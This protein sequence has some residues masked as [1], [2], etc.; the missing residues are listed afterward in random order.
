MSTHA[1]VTLLKIQRAWNMLDCSGEVTYRVRES[2]GDS[3][4]SIEEVPVFYAASER[5]NM[6]RLMKEVIQKGQSSYENPFGADDTETLLDAFAELS[7]SQKRR[8]SMLCLRCVKKRVSLGKDD[9]VDVL[10]AK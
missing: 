10:S 8:L 9:L 5:K 3:D 6:L 4:G 1:Y 2:D 7:A